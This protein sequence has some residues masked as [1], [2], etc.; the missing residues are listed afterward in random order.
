MAD[1]ARRGALRV[2]AGGAVQAGAGGA[3][4]E[5]FAAGTASEEE[6]LATI[7]RYHQEYGYLLDPHTAVGVCVA[8]KVGRA[9]PPGAEAAARVGRATSLHAGAAPVLCLATAHPAKFPDAIRKAT[10]QDI[11]RHPA[12]DALMHLPTRCQVLPNDKEA[13]RQFIVKTIG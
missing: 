9:T 2:E 5:D 8:E 4:D 12:I 7:G 6:V 3:V 11:A 1:F 13:V 10:G